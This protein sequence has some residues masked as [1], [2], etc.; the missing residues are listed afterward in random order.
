MGLLPHGKFQNLA[1]LENCKINII[2][3]LMIDEKCVKTIKLL[4]NFGL[5][6]VEERHGH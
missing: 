6:K 3:C 5:Y 1:S 2:L 4:K